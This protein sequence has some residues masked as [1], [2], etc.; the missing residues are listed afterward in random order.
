[1]SGKEKELGSCGVSVVEPQQLELR[2]TIQ[3]IVAGL[4]GSQGRK[5]SVR[6]CKLKEPLMIGH[7]RWKGKKEKEKKKVFE[8]LR[9]CEAATLNGKP[10]MILIGYGSICS[11][12]GF[13]KVYLK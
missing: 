12:V 9:A 11:F 3:E 5:L 6:W 4:G 8:S 1:M 2:V 10:H 7:G 13:D